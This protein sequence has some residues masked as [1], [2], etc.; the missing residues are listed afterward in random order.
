MARAAAGAGAGPRPPR[1]NQRPVRT[2]AGSTTCARPSSSGAIS[3]P[4]VRRHR[5]RRPAPSS[6]ARCHPVVPSRPP[7]AARRRSRPAAPSRPWPPVVVRRG[8]AGRFRLRCLV[9]V[10]RGRVGR[11]RPA[12][13]CRWGPVGPSRLRAPVVARRGRRAVP[14]RWSRPLARR[15]PPR[16]AGESPSRPGPGRS[17]VPGPVPRART[18]RLSPRTSVAPDRPPDLCPPVPGPGRAPLAG[19]SHPPPRHIPVRRPVPSGVTTPARRTPRRAAGRR[20]TPLRPPGGCVPVRPPSRPP[21]RRPARSPVPPSG[22]S[23]GCRPV[24]CRARPH[25]AGCPTV[26]RTVCPSALGGRRP[27]ESSLP[28]ARRPPNPT[29]GGRRTALRTRRRLDVADA[30]RQNPRPPRSRWAAVR[31]VRCRG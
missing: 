24:P 7:S 28:A 10:R 9:V 17:M 29:P 11:F 1:R 20:L 19:S 25:R 27:A 5:T 22:P 21:V 18:L 3:A 2:S 6:P 15:P 26:G 8:R 12:V 13:G 30:P 23:P 14:C 4:T 31:A 16:R